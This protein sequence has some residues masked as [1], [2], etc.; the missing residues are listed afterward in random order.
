MAKQDRIQDR[1]LDNGVCFLTGEVNEESTQEI[2]EWI[3]YE[4]LNTK[5]KK[6]R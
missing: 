1:L 4:N 2:M 5:S 6:K 3:Q